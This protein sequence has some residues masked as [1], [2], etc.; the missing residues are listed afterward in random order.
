MGKSHSLWIAAL[1][2]FAAAFVAPS[3]PALAQQANIG[4]AA[5][6][7]TESA[8]VFDTAEQHKIRVVVV[9]KGL[10]HP[11]SVALLPSGDALVSE[12]GG[13]LRIVHNAGGSGGKAPSLD[14]EPIAGIPPLQPAYRNGGLHDLALHPQFSQNGL[15]YFTFNK[16]GNP[17][18]A[19]AKPP[20][21]RESIVTLMRGKLVGN[22]LTKVEELFAGESGATSGSRIA[23]GKDGFVYMTTGAPFDDAAQRE[24]SVYGKVL[25]MTDTGKVPA[26][27]PF[28]GHAGARGEVF[29]MGHRDQLGLTVHPVTGAV[30][31]AE[32]GPNGGDEVNLILSGHNYG[33]PKVTFGRTYEGPRMTESPL[34]PGVDEPLILW[35]PSIGPSG[36]AFYTGDRFP[37]WKGNLFVG[38]VRRGEVPRTGGLERVVVTDK[39]DEIR[40]ET[41]LTDL[42]Q[43]IRDVRQGPDGLLYVLT[44]EDDGALLRIEPAT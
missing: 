42:H 10:N 41:L 36:L 16:P 18:P 31:N 13:A 24:N 43:R 19:D 20:I 6:T 5:V 34:A 27:N 28:V 44:D 29:T 1:V 35:L 9:A 21:R 7:L 4:V 3:R 26:D 12:R 15:L 22:K 39:L 25:R 37:Q 2:T 32:H 30:L 14:A 38:S 23:F 33:W 11:F 40:R 17:P 8:Y